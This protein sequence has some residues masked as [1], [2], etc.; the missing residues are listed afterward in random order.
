[1]KASTLQ[2]KEALVREIPIQQSPI[3]TSSFEKFQLRI[4][5]FR[6]LMSSA[7]KHLGSPK[8]ALKVS[9]ILKD[10][11]EKTFGE[12]LL[13]KVAKVDG[14]YYWRLASPGFP[15]PA[16]TLSRINEMNRVMPFKPTNGL[17]ILL[18]GIT[19]KC[20][21]SCEHCYEWDRMNEKEKLSIDD[22]T[23]IIQKYQD[24]GTTQ[25]MLG[26]GEP[27]L[28]IKDIY[29]L[30]ENAKDGTDFWIVT[31]GWRFTTEYATRLKS[32][33]LSG[34]MVS[35]DHYI[36][37]KHDEFR[38]REGSYDE[39]INAVLLAKEAK[40]VTGISLCPTKEFTTEE[41]L[42]AYMELG[43]RLGVTFVQ[44]FEPKAVGR[45][46][47]QDVALSEKHFKLLEKF[48]LE[49]NSGKEY[50]DYPIINY[51]GYHQRRFGC[52][53]SGDYYLYVDTDGD[54]HKCPLCAGKVCNALAFPVED[55]VNLLKQTS[56]CS[57][58]H[59]SEL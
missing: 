48:Y 45:Y 25:I 53:G 39:A 22:L 11:Y 34:V 43:K 7:L 55:T 44:I 38:G 30:L 52:F 10:K 12:K 5:L 32:K 14:K 36:P 8:K 59:Q 54:V 21:L 23:Q 58:F 46:K 9:K 56:G 49:Y 27:L 26:G 13:S 24:Y 51:T 28:R 1:M 41:N 37:E 18:V 57:F 17:G 33:G 15:S 3:V 50:K 2:K 16:A 31:S 47:G 20:P 40:L 19:K 35:L 6:E 29:T 42:R 4:V